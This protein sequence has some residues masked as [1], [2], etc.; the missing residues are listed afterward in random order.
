MKKWLK[1]SALGVW[2]GWAGVFWAH[3]PLPAGAEIIIIDFE[4]LSLL[5][6]SHHEGT[7]TTPYDSTATLN[8]WTSRGM[9]FPLYWAVDHYEVPPG[10]G[11][12]YDYTWWYGVTYSN[13]TWSGTPP[14]GLAGQYTAYP[15]GGAG[16]SANYA[17]FFCTEDWANSGQT[18][19]FTLDLPQGKQILGLSVTNN[20]YV[21]DTLKNGDPYGFTRR[22]GWLD[23]NGDGDY[24]DPGDYAGT[25]P[26]YFLLTIQGLDASGQ[27]ISAP[28][29]E[30][31][32]ADYRFADSNQDYILQTWQFV[33]LSGLQGA[34][35]LLFRLSSTDV[36]QYG[37]NTPAYFLVDNIVLGDGQPVVPEP[38]SGLLLLLA[39]VGLWAFR[40]RGSSR[41][42]RR[43]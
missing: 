5:P 15:S 30:V 38:D 25:Y 34:E 3:G 32:L 19:S 2:F 6:N 31:Y 14:A 20:C 43:T 16:G 29:V 39:G 11:Q 33:D 26:D 4:D 27:P 22:F 36:G 35:K 23:A 18:Y 24:D 9:T 13:H 28:A 10:S 37:M 40:R 41:P 21:W 42:V 8:P 12:Y 1:L 17:V 7:D